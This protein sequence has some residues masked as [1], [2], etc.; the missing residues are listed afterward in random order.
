MRL[1]ARSF[2]IPKAMPASQDTGQHAEAWRAADLDDVPDRF[3][4]ADGH[5][6]GIMTNTASKNY[7]MTCESKSTCEDSGIEWPALK[8][9]IPCMA[10]VIQLTLGEFMG[11]LGMKGQMR[12]WEDHDGDQQSG[13]NET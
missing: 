3:Q 2:P 6:L 9:Q 13:E 11:S 1:I 4:L 7:L 5:W 12:S 10:H 8:N